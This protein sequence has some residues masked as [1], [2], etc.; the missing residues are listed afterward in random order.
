M[1]NYTPLNKMKKIDIGEKFL[2]IISVIPC[3][4]FGLLFFSQP[5]SAKSLIDVYQF[6]SATN[7][8]STLQNKGLGY[9]SYRVW[10]NTGNNWLTG[11][12]TILASSGGHSNMNI[13]TGNVFNT[14]V[15]TSG[16]AYSF[17]LKPESYGCSGDFYFELGDV[18]NPIKITY[19]VASDNIVLN[20]QGGGSATKQFSS[21]C[22]NANWHFYTVNI[23]TDLI[24]IYKDGVLFYIIIPNVNIDFSNYY[25]NVLS[26]NSTSDMVETYLNFTDIAIIDTPLDV[27]DILSIY[28][29][30]QSINNY[31][32]T[33]PPC[34]SYV[35]S[36][37]GACNTDTN[38]KYRTITASTPTSCDYTNPLSSAPILGADCVETFDAQTVENLYFRFD[39]FLNYCRTDMSCKIPFNF[40]Q[41]IFGP[42]ATGT[43]FYYAS[44]TATAINLGDINLNTQRSLGIYGVGNL[45]ATSSASSTAFSY[46]QIKPHSDIF[47]QDYATSTVAFWFYDS[48]TFSQAFDD[49]WNASNTPNIL[50]IDT[51][52][53]A[54]TPEQWASTSSIPFLGINVELTLCNT[55]KWVLDVGMQPMIIAQQKVLSLKDSIMTMFPFSLMTSV[56]NNWKSATNLLT[57]YLFVKP[58]YAGD[59]STTTGAYTGDFSFVAPNLFG[60]NTGSTTITLLSKSNLENLL[61]VEGFYWFNMVC[62]ILIW[63]AFFGYCW[64]LITERLHIE[65]L[66][67]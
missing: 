20:S 47:N 23:E 60:D 38:R 12:G 55:K 8:N 6:N 44:S 17:Y 63:L 13:G 4:I 39:N 28:N 9:N 33:L 64:W 19:D 27:A 40:D 37:W 18:T 11:N 46:Y 67:H 30:G 26:L 52:K 7:W 62:R 32:F 16:F 1:A 25:F 65:I 22:D 42:N 57:S 50:G 35:Y 56:Q 49:V 43:V 36:D 29:S 58:C 21:T 61:G 41:N 34:T 53:L 66:K 31:V 51:Y 10:L 14:R 54:C 2:I 3:L 15:S 5:A 59:F 24:N 45:I 48:A